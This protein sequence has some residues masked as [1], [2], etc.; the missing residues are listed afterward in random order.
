VGCSVCIHRLVGNR[1]RRLR[2]ILTPQWVAGRRFIGTED[3]EATMEISLGLFLLPRGRPRPR[4]P[5]TTP[6]SRSITPASAIRRSAWQ[7]RN[8]KQ[9][10]E[11]EDD[12]VEKTYSGRI[13]VFPGEIRGPY[14]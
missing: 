8:P 2:F 6:V 5:T 11:D 14:L 12:A 7:A 9:D 13:R 4:L 10:L 3:D 1:R